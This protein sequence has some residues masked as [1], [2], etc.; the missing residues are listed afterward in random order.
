MPS[1]AELRQAGVKFKLGSSKNLFDVK[2]NK[3]RGRLE[4]PRLLVIDQTEILFRNL[5]SF[6]NTRSEE[7]NYRK[8]AD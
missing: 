1:A 8:L 4:I 6:G 3:S 7:R 2:F 5:Q